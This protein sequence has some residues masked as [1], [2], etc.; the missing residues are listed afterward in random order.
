MTIEGFWD[1]IAADGVRPPTHATPAIDAQACKRTRRAKHRPA[2]VVQDQQHAESGG[3][4]P[5]DPKLYLQEVR[6]SFVLSIQR[7]PRRHRTVRHIGMVG[8]FTMP[9]RGRITR[10]RT[11]T[12]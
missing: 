12:V 6:C 11:Y 4:T 2:S 1:S 8:Q 5:K 7:G 3:R 10:A 9:H